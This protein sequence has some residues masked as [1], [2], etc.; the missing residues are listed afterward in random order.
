[1]LESILRKF[2]GNQASIT[3]FDIDKDQDLLWRKSTLHRVLNKITPLLIYGG[4]NESLVETINDMGN[5]LGLPSTSKSYYAISKSTELI[6]QNLILFSKVNANGKW[7]FSLIQVNADDIKS[8][9]ITAWIN[10]KMANIL[11]I[12]SDNKSTIFVMSYNPFCFKENQHGA[13]L[14]EE[15]NLETLPSILEK[16]ERIFERKVRNLQNYPLKAFVLKSNSDQ[17]KI[18]DMEMRKVFEKTL[19][20]KFTLFVPA[21]SRISNE[22]FNGKIKF[23]LFKNFQF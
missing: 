13:F 11:I 1:M 23:L 19:K 17:N 18:L 9:L 2:I 5:E 3:V 20:T 8:L 15:V 22:S 16:I 10:F 21:N 14:T 6:K 4:L 12:F 7:I